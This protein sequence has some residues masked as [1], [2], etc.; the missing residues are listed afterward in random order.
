MN[1]AILKGHVGQEPNVR[2]TE[3]GRKVMTFTMAT[4]S[5]YKSRDGEWVDEPPVW[6]NIVAWGHLAENAVVKGNLVEVKGKISNR[7]YDDKDGVKRYITE[8][9]ATELDVIKVMRRVSDVP[10]P[11]DPKEGRDADG[12][13]VP[14]KMNEGAAVD[15]GFFEN[16]I[17]GGGADDLPF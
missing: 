9:V 12:F 17:R 14:S 5:R 6:H 15:A 4:T 11:P 13:T 1:F 8:V 3:N 7:S 10:L 2:T 16:D